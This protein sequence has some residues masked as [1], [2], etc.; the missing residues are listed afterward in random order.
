MFFLLGVPLEAPF[1]TQT[2]KQKKNYS[3][4]FFVLFDDEKENE[5]KKQKKYKIPRKMR[6][7]LY[8][9][10]VWC[11][12]CTFVI[13]C[14]TFFCSACIYFE[15]GAHVYISL[16]WM[17]WWDD[18]HSFADSVDDANERE[19]SILWHF[20]VCGWRG[21]NRKNSNTSSTELNDGK[22]R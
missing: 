16:K 20:D 2:V 10:R 3:Q 14:Y 1:S 7:S 6:W 12:I 5:E 13:M 21:E 17:T 9:W 19:I 22:T 8:I 4:F 18:M 15:R 11:S